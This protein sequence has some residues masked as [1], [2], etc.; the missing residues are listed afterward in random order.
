MRNSTRTIKTALSFSQAAIKGRFSAF[1]YN[2]IYKEMRRRKKSLKKC[3]REGAAILSSSIVFADSR[4]SYTPPNKR[5]PPRLSSTP[6]FML[7]PEKTTFFDP[8]AW[9]YISARNMSSEALVSGVTQNGGHP[10]PYRTGSNAPETIHNAILEG[11]LYSGQFIRKTCKR[12][13]ASGAA[14]KF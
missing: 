9:A 6:P 5:E 4:S 7:S 14:P 2:K 11:F 12:R 8:R 3:T 1:R 13:T 10:P